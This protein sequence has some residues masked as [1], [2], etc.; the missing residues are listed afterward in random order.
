MARGTK[1]IDPPSEL[2]FARP[3]WSVILKEEVLRHRTW[4][5]QEERFLPSAEQANLV[6]EETRRHLP[7]L[8]GDAT[9]QCWVVTTYLDTIDHHYFQTAKPHSSNTSTRMRFREYLRR[10]ANTRTFRYEPTCF[11]ERKQNTEEMRLKHRVEIPKASAHAILCGRLGLGQCKEARAIT[12]ELENHVLVPTLVC[13][14]QRRTFGK[15]GG[16]R[17]TYDREL[18]Y[19][20][21]RSDLYDTMDA[22]TPTTVSLFAKGPPHILE[23]K[24]PAPHELP[25]WL[26]AL[27]KPLP[28]ANHFSKFQA[29][30]EQLSVQL[31][32]NSLLEPPKT[33][34][35]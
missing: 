26:R 29:G 4:S 19:Y 18:A 34:S 14:Y 8:R 10:C 2:S 33:V 20:K 7:S 30:M 31:A 25:E 3:G 23:I 1:N 9:D 32:E 13:I 17:V 21:P 11:L 6:L 12:V 24:S 28:P 27:I 22:I 35:A 15:D 16:L 5:Q